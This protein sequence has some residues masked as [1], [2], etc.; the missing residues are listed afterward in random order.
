MKE[1]ERRLIIVSGLSGAGKTVV[2]NMLEDLSYY[3]IDNLPIS[4]LN[5]LIK[6]FSDKNNNLAKHIAIGIDARN[7]LDDFSFIPETIASLNNK[8]IPA[9]LIFIEAEDDVLTKRFSETRRKH[10]LSSD[11]ISLSDAIKQERNIIG[12]LA[13]AADLSIDTSHMQ[14][15]ELRDIV[16]KRVDERKKARLSLQFMSF[17][18]KNGIPKDADFVFDLR[19]LPNPYWNKDLRK[20]SGKDVPVID[21]LLKQNSA[22][23]ML[24]D[25]EHFLKHW[26]P[27]FEADNRSYLSIA[28]GCTGGHHRSV[29]I[30]EQLA[31]QFNN[32]DKQVIIRHRDL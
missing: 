5:T 21:F 8:D 28:F 20:Y 9:E 1:Q 24:E 16:R 6:Q 4:L 31:K 22:R 15:H 19:C 13:E 12:A 17:G 10:P 23:Q 32:M 2:L 26:I 11:D 18:Y 27:Q 3:T 14:L 7:S 29:F 30:A 25:L